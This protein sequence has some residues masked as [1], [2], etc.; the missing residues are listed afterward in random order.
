MAEARSRFSLFR[1]A[2]TIFGAA[3]T[4]TGA[5]LFLTFFL[6]ELF[7]Y[8]RQ[9]LSGHAVLP[10]LPGLFVAGLVLMPIGVWLGAPAARPD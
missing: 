10:G 1:N 8:A 9:P 5:V 6:L 3:L 4:T 7:G 2:V